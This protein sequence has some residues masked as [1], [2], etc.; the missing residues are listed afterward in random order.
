MYEETVISEAV[1]YLSYIRKTL[2][3]LLYFFNCDFATNEYNCQI[4][5][6]SINYF[7]STY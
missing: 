7:N 4:Y 1:F 6:F 2:Y 5:T 3:S